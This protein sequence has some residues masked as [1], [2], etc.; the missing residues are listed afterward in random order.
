MQ[1]QLKGFKEQLNGFK[2]QLKGYKKQLE[3]C[4]DIDEIERS[5]EA[6]LDN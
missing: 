3:G 1:K 4:F 6:M 2:E 5:S